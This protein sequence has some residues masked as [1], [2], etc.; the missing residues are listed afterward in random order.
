MKKYYK[1]NMKLR[2]LLVLLFGFFFLNPVS[3]ANATPVLNSFIPDQDLYPNDSTWSLNISTNFSDTDST[4][5]LSFSPW[6][7]HST[8]Y[9]SGNPYYPHFGPIPSWLQFDNTS[10]VFSLAS[11]A[12]VG[13]YRIFVVAQNS[14]NFSTA[15]DD[16]NLIINEPINN[17]T[18]PVPEPTTML[19]FGLGLLGLAGVNRKKQ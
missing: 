5:I 13:A 16:F 15:Y 10:G 11:D 6:N 12:E 9:N 2:L 3:I 18:S 7:Y 14:T 1:V 17:G 4:A 8:Q 19:L